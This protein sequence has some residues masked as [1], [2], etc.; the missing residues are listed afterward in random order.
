DGDPDHCAGDRQRARGRHRRSTP[1]APADART[2]AGGARMIGVEVNGELVE[3]SCDPDTRLLD[4]LR[5]HAGLSSVREGC[6]VGA[7]GACTVLIDGNP[8]SSCLVYLARCEGKHVETIEAR[9]DELDAVQQA[10]LEY[11]ALQCGYCTPGFVLSTRALLAE[12]PS[13]SDEEIREYL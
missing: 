2:C 3:F 10:F 11:G 6:S 12:N 13:P 5:E 1:L 7:C 8:V 9:G 4:A